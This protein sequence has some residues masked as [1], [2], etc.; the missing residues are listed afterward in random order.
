MHNSRCIATNTRWIV[1]RADLTWPNESHSP[2][3]PTAILV[4]GNKLSTYQVTY[5]PLSPN[6]S[7]PER[8]VFLISKAGPSPPLGTMTT[9]HPSP[10]LPRQFH[11]TLTL[12]SQDSSHQSHTHTPDKASFISHSIHYKTFSMY[13]LMQAHKI[14]SHPTP[15]ASHWGKTPSGH[16]PA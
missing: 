7:L 2:W 9:D 15:M 3:T 14:R 11:P 13:S 1:D 6:H 5:P 4:W 16:Q 12:F 8:P 10:H